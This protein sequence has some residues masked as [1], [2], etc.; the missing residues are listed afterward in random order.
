MRDYLFLEEFALAWSEHRGEP[1]GDTR[2][3]ILRMF[4]EGRFERLGIDGGP[5][6]VLMIQEEGRKAFPDQY[7]EGMPYGREE[8]FTQ[9]FFGPCSLPE[10]GI[11]SS[12]ISTPQASHDPRG[13]RF[14]LSFRQDPSPELLQ[15]AFRT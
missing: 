9:T 2:T 15:A 6:T 4:W 10:W 5:G 8:F 11:W 14:K 1:L 12:L 3:E 7:F 13:L